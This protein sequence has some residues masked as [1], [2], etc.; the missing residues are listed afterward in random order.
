MALKYHLVQRL[1]KSKDAA[2]G[3]KLYYGQIR[4]QQKLEFNKLCEIIASY[5]TASRGDVMLVID[6]LLYVMRQHLENGEV[7]QVGDFGNFRM[8]AGSKGTAVADDCTTSLFKKGRIVFT[9]G[10][11]LKEVT[12]KPKFEKIVPITSSGNSGSGSDRPEIE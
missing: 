1:D 5:S 11:M 2:A 7:V 4:A 12:A 6:G 3:S 8:L 9:P 10:P